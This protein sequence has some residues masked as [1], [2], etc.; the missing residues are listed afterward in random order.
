[1]IISPRVVLLTLKQK[2]TSFG[3]LFLTIGLIMFATNELT[4][5]QKKKRRPFWPPLCW[6]IQHL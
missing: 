3:L 5:K 1:M 2:T 4:R 6:S